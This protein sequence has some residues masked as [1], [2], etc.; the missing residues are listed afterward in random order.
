[1][2]IFKSLGKPFEVLAAV[3]AARTA[4]K[5]ICAGTFSTK[6]STG[7]LVGVRA[8]GDVSIA[9]QQLTNILNE[10]KSIAGGATSEVDAVKNKLSL[11]NFIALEGSSSTCALLN[12]VINGTS[13]EKAADLRDVSAKAVSDAAAALLKSNPSYAVFGATAGTPS[14]AAIQKILA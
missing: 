3:L 1:L 14:Y 11:E 2:C 4:S 7:G 13:P 8:N 12:S 5:S 10:L 6:Y 9:S